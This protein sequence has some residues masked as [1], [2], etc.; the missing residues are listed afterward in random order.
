MREQG[1]RLRHFGRIRRNGLRTCG[2]SRISACPTGHRCHRA[3]TASSLSAAQR[4][5][6]PH[7]AR[8][9][10][11]TWGAWRMEVS[12]GGHAGPPSRVFTAASQARCAVLLRW[13]GFSHG[14]EGLRGL[15]EALSALRH[16]PQ[17]SCHP[18]A[19][20]MRG[21]GPLGCYVVAGSRA[22][23]QRWLAGGANRCASRWRCGSDGATSASSA[24]AVV[25]HSSHEFGNCG[26]VLRSW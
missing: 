24:R 23:C 1:G 14:R 18:C 25:Q 22:R 5:P 21:R 20:S 19:G 2:D 9:C 26:L 16:A 7:S 3:L 11:A 17:A 10:H 8:G 13:H 4:P 15:L 12:R 6:P